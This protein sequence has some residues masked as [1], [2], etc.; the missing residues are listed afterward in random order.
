MHSSVELLIASI[1]RANPMQ[2]KFVQDSA[3]LL[4]EEELDFLQR[5]LHFY[6]CEGMTIDQLAK[7][8]QVIVEDAI[9]EQVYFARHGRY[10][11]SSFAEACEKV[12]HNAE[13]MFAYMH[14]LILTQFL[15]PN[16]IR[17]ARWFIEKL[18]RTR[19]GAYL[20]IGPGH[21]YF[22]MNAMRR[23]VFSLYD[24]VD[25]SETSIALTEKLVRGGRF[26][27]FTN[28]RLQQADFLASA[29]DRKYEA[30]VMGEVLEHV[31]RP[32]LFL[33]KIRAL[34]AP[35]AFIYVSTVI[36]APMIDH[37][38]LFSSEAAIQKLFTEARLA[39]C[40]RLVLPSHG[41]T[42]EQCE[43]HRLAINIAFVLAPA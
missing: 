2:A 1:G 23:G 15:W 31:E 29:F 21:G 12:Y 40:D 32:E 27:V 9:R 5:Y 26:G 19:D 3:S 22:F 17:M 11:L 39:V 30:I 6:E 25:I 20:E 28:C 42:I 4:N 8:Y 34:A 38:T 41:R 24:G 14:G 35:G 37:I 7:C 36:N 18:P 43:A 10:R 13:Y 33:Q 16:H